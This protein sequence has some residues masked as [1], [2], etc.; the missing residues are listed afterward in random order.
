MP[1][2]TAFA[3]GRNAALLRAIDQSLAVVSFDTDGRIIE[4]N[5]NFLKVMGYGLREVAGRPH[6]LFMPQGQA[7]SETYRRF[8]ADLRAGHFQEGEFRR[9][10]AGGRDIWLRASYNPILDGQ[11]RVTRIVKI[12]SDITTE[13]LSAMDDAGQIAAIQRSQAVISFDPDGIILDANANFLSVMGYSLA[14]IK[15]QHHRLFVD[16]H[17]AR[18][19]D[20]AAFWER[21]KRGEYQAAEYRRLARG[22]REVWIRATYNPIVDD[23]GRVLKVVKFA[24]DVTEDKRRN[25]D[26]EGQIAALQRAQAVIAFTLDGQII[27]ANDN[28]L[29]ATGYGRDEVVGKHHRI[30]VAP[31]YAESDDYRQ[32]WERLA[33]GESMQAIYQRYGK[34][35]R[36]IWLQATYNPILDALGRPVRVVK[37]ATDITGNMEARARA[38]AAAEG[39]LGNVE[40]VAA[41]AEEMNASVAEIV[42]GMARSKAAV[43]RIHARTGTAGQSTAAM[44]QAAQSM[45]GVVQ[46]IAQ[47]AGQINLLALNATIESARAGDAGRG[48]AVVAN[49]VK[50]LAGQT[51]AATARI[52]SEIAG[53]QALSDEVA[54]ALEMITTAIGEVQGYVDATA[55]SIQEQAAIT[56][57]ISENMHVTAEGVAD[58]GR[59][60]D[61]WIIGMEE[62]RFDARVR[63]SKPVRLY[64]AGGLTLEGALRNVSRTG[65]KLSVDNINA[66]PD[67]FDLGVDGDRRRCRVVR[68]GNGEIGVKFV[69]AATQAA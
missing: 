44:R 4:A 42:T 24:V 12:A 57:D 41:A 43:D 67:T 5:D 51:S 18:R 20:Y 27:D 31:A 22:G 65:A 1:L 56:L 17:D 69:D 46:L 6:S 68:R 10:G 34:D 37:Y 61:D 38:V 21:L 35:G 60:L 9:V 2:R 30:F 8:W 50:I 47:V 36:A 28:F 49:E 66:V 29:G 48:F 26:Y 23:A 62:R 15:G 32:F 11:G 19:P 40:A 25:A 13:K 39:T 64:L 3:F 33:R 14:E 52:S 54:G 45:D 59:T 55:A 63:L 16:P 58:I 53:M 7:D